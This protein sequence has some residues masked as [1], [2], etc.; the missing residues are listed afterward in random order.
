MLNW[1]KLESVMLRSHGESLNNLQYRCSSLIGSFTSVALLT[2]RTLILTIRVPVLWILSW[3]REM[4]FRVSARKPS[5][6]TG[7]SWLVT[8]TGYWQY[9]YYYYCSTSIYWV[10]ADFSGSW[11]YAQ[12]VGV[13]G[14]GISPSQGRYLLA[15]QHKR[16]INAQ[17]TDIHAL[18][19]IR[20]NDPS[21]RAS[22]GSS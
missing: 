4:S 1:S 17:N 16:R 11:S 9:Y 10:L 14:R 22:E 5:V 19:E 18:S 2:N 13:L 12:S 21:V 20:T 8:S 3:K 7:L 15:E 6:L